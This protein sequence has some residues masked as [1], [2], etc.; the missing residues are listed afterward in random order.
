M[1]VCK[2]GGS[3]CKIYNQLDHIN[4][5]CWRG[6]VITLPCLN[7]RGNYYRIVWGVM[8]I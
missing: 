1:N 6:I 3:E 2:Y 8:D 4:F 5:F 7:L